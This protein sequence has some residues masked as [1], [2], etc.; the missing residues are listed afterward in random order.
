MPIFDFDNFGYRNVLKLAPDAFVT[1]NGS[2]GAKIVS[3]L[4]QA[5]WQQVEAQGGITSINV[6]AATQSGS[7]RATLQIVAPKY[8]GLHE[9]YYVTLPSG[10][11]LP[12]FLPLMEV[13]IYMKGRFTKYTQNQ[14]TYYPVFWG[15]ITGISEDYNDGVTTFS[16]TCSDVLTWWKYQK[17]TMN[18]S[19]FTSL[20]GGPKIENFPTVFK[21][22]NPWQIIMHLVYDT[23]WKSKGGA[24]HNFTFP[25][26]SNIF[27]QPNL[28]NVPLSTIGALANKV[29]EYWSNR[30]SFTGERVP[31]EMFGLS[32]QISAEGLNT[33]RYLTLQGL[34]VRSVKYN[35]KAP[36][37]IKLDYNLLA[38]VQPFGDIDLFGDGAQPVEMTKLEIATK[39]CDMVHMEFFLD[40]NGVLVFKPPFYNLDVTRADVP[41]Y[42]IESSDVIN[43]NSS[44]NS[45]HICTFLE[46]TGPQTQELQ[47][48]DQIGFHIDWDLMARYGMRHQKAFIPYGND[49]KSLRLIAAAEMARINGQATTGSVSVPLRPEMRLGYPVYIAHKDEFFYVSGISHSFSYG[50]SATTE[51]SLEMK[52]ERIYDATGDISA[53]LPP[54][55]SSTGAKA[56]NTSNVGRVLKG[57]VW[58]FREVSEL[59]ADQ[60]FAAQGKE[61][62]RQKAYELAQFDDGTYHKSLLEKE[63]YKRITELITGPKFN[64][65]YEISPA[66]ERGRAFVETEQNPDIVNESGEK[67]TIVSNEMVMIT[68]ETVP[69]TDAQGYRH[70]G[71]FPYGA[72]LRLVN[73]VDFIDES[74][75][76][77]VFGDAVRK[78]IEDEREKASPRE[79]KPVE[80]FKPISDNEESER[81]KVDERWND[82][83]ID[84]DTGYPSSTIPGA[85]FT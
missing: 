14:P 79:I 67:S 75:P 29:N 40:M 22:K 59:Q 51:L 28:G 36:A 60:L 46:V 61:S 32:Q 11:R 20:F 77:E 64:G 63:K 39:V 3:P 30:F 49:S 4:K 81:R 80:P 26:L 69:Y 72:N 7:G 43:F 16:L 10:V 47:S 85:R 25:N 37:D 15:L 18:P 83:L 38:R 62:A 55:I 17:I 66:R 44:V 35:E 56:E 21:A 2:L 19:I 42:V 84:E 54:N 71:A 8:K 34:D 5:Q 6:N 70:I 23:A 53:K 58:R 48:I 73:G 65:F 1:F 45:E 9:D 31:L 82:V 78:M 74:K 50:S 68:G 27:L 12:Y 13:K 76:E 41:Y 57:F 33:L 52:R 24:T